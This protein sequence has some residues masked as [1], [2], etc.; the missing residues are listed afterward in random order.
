MKYLKHTIIAKDEEVIP[1]V[2][3]ETIDKLDE[4]LLEIEKKA[5]PVWEEI[6]KFRNKKSVLLL[7]E[8]LV[9]IGENYKATPLISYG[10][11][12]LSANQLFNIDKELSLIQQFPDFVKKLNT[13]YN[14]K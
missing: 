9:E 14:G 10:N 8:L 1:E 7:A 12:L 4:V 13:P 2:A 5:M 3:Y 6:K 11:E